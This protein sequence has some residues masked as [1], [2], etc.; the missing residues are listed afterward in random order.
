MIDQYKNFLELQTNHR[1]EVDFR[2]QAV[3]RPGAG[4]II[5]AVHAGGIEPGCSELARAIAGGDFSLYLF[6]GFGKNTQV[7]HI[8]STNFD[9]SLCLEMLQQHQTALSLHGFLGTD[10]DPSI[11]LGGT[12]Q[13][14]IKAMIFAL[15]SNGYSASINTGKYAA[16][17]P[18]NVCNRASSGKGVQIELSASLRRQFFEDFSS[19]KGRKT[20]TPQFEHF[21][22]VVRNVLLAG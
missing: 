7:L 6:E 16:T 2:I 15:E 9:E 12:D 22:Q 19:Q 13:A 11:Y 1:D 17:D 8:T 20:I 4:L 3:S 14:L 18:Q 21:V 5:L 10:A